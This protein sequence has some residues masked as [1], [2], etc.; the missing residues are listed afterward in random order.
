MAAVPGAPG[1]LSPLQRVLGR[2]EPAAAPGRCL[3][4]QHP[5]AGPA[6]TR[7][8]PPRRRGRQ[9]RSPPPARR[10]PVAR[11]TGSQRPPI[12]SAARAGRSGASAPAPPP[13]ATRPSLGPASAG[14]RCPP[15]S[16]PLRLGTARAA[17]KRQE[18]WAGAPSRGG[19]GEGPRCVPS[20]PASPLPHA[21]P[22]AKMPRLTS[23]LWP[24]EGRPG[25]APSRSHAPSTRPAPCPAWGQSS[26]VQLQVEKTRLEDVEKQG[27]LRATCLLSPAVAGDLFHCQAQHYPVETPGYVWLQTRGGGGDLGF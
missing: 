3:P 11:A 2:G 22:R 26:P 14:R 17:G 4:R 7:A 15:A 25:P 8:A 20:S 12:S 27:M 18:M 16:P 24:C 9:R 23:S 19:V 10:P 13:G 6:A 5:R 21:H 1:R